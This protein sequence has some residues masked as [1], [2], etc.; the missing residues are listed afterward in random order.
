MIN[1]DARSLQLMW[2][3]PDNQHKHMHITI[4]LFDAQLSTP[5]HALCD[6]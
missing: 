6:Q 5:M 2:L 4:D 1:T 3:M